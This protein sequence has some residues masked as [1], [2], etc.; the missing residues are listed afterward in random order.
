MLVSFSQLPIVNPTSIITMA[1]LIS[2]LGLIAL[3]GILS[4]CEDSPSGTNTSTN[5][6]NL[7]Q[8]THQKVNAYRASRGLPALTFNETI[9]VQ[10][11]KH[12]E[13]MAKGIVPFSHDGFQGRADEIQKTIAFTTVSENVALNLGFSD[14]SQKAV[15]DWIASND[16]RVNMEGDF[17]LT[18]I[19]VAKRSDGTFFFTQIFAKR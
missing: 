19:G 13:N 18:G 11:R 6:G 4:A 2:L 17:N 3:M 5:S 9:A 7:E 14:A 12:S 15:D 16:H 8:P 1:R 10:A